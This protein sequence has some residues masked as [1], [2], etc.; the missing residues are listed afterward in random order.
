[1]SWGRSSGA[2]EAAL[3]VEALDKGLFMLRIE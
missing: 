3:V 2:G 1:M